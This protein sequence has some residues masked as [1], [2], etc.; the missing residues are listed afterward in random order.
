MILVGYGFFKALILVRQSEP[1]ASATS[2]IQDFQQAG[3]FRPQDYSFDLAFTLTKELDPSYGK[4]QVNWVNYFINNTEGNRKRE[5]KIVAVNIQKCGLQRHYEGIAW[6]VGGLYGSLTAIGFY[7]VRMFCQK[8]FMSD[9]MKQIYQIRKHTLKETP[10]S[11]Q[12]EKINKGT[13]QRNF[14]NIPLTS[15]KSQN[16]NLTNDS[17][18]QVLSQ[19]ST[20]GLNQLNQDDPKFAYENVGFDNDS[21]HRFQQFDQRN[22]LYTNQRTHTTIE[23]DQESSI[24][25]KVSELELFGNRYEYSKIKKSTSIIQN[26]EVKI[27]TKLKQQNNQFVLKKGSESIDVSNKFQQGIDLKINESQMGIAL[28]E[29]DKLNDQDIDNLLSSFTN[30]IRFN[31]GTKKVLDYIFKCFCL[32][33]KS[34]IKQYNYS[35]HIFLKGQKKLE[36]E[37]DVIQLLKNM[38]KFKL[39]QQAMLNQKNRMLLK[40]Q[41]FN[42]IETDS[43]SSN[44]DDGKMETLSLLEN[45]NP[46]IKLVIFSKIQKMMKQFKD[47]KLKPIEMNLIRGVFQR[48]LKDYDEDDRS[49][50]IYIRKLVFKSIRK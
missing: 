8:M 37:L 27:K 49:Q 3:I 9:I 31:Y 6:E 39:I 30:R 7:I 20:I 48:R 19:K 35:H 46:L 18:M 23:T 43:S 1:Q 10:Q 47:K 41:R 36:Q 14:Q 34:N 32:R 15:S 38:R 24:L 44:S 33:K 45:K 26:H 16:Q 13:L 11:K 4:I 40:F 17:L 29:K 5:K 22:R 42:L 28:Q 50:S 21:L 2:L 12:Q 25:S